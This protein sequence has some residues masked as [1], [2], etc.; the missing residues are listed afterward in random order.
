MRDDKRF[1]THT[2][3]VLDDLEQVKVLGGFR[4]QADPAANRV[5]D[6][7]HRCR[8]GNGDSDD[9]AIGQQNLE[10]NRRTLIAILLQSIRQKFLHSVALRYHAHRADLLQILFQ[11]ASSCVK[12]LLAQSTM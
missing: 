12:L 7:L 5:V 6:V 2:E 1:L 10:I 3:I 11:T 4:V 9:F 8:F